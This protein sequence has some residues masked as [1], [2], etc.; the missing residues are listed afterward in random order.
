MS[1]VESENPNTWR[2]EITVPLGI[3]AELRESLFTAVADAVHD[4]Q[5][6]DRVGWDP[7]VAAHAVYDELTEDVRVG[8]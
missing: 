2:I 1:S 7:F 8:G 3:G 6:E 4:W 5:P